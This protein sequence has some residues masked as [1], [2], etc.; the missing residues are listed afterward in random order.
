[1][2][3]IAGFSRIIDKSL[4]LIR[5]DMKNVIRAYQNVSFTKARGGTISK[6]ISGEFFEF[7][8]Q[9]FQTYSF[10]WYSCW[11]KNTKLEVNHLLKTTIGISHMA[12][13]L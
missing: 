7:R 13:Y 4:C 5:P 10:C 1:M 3:Q 12:T 6:M 11:I 9:V 2:S 8:A